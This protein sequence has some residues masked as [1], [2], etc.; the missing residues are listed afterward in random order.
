MKILI[1]ECTAEELRANRTVLD[2]FNEALSN[3]TRPMF[4]VDFDI[5][6]VSDVSDDTQEE[7]YDGEF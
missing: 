5:S 6:K 1:V 7:E 4:G 2:T 3:F